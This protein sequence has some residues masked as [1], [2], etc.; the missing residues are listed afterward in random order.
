MSVRTFPVASRSF[1]QFTITGHTDAQPLA[2]EQPLHDEVEDILR[3]GN[4]VIEKL[5]VY[6]G[7]GEFIRKV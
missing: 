3:R 4:L 5:K 1:K 2:E 7:C 6:S